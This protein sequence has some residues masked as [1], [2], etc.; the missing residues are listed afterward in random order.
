MDFPA[1][2]SEPVSTPRGLA[3]ALSVV[4]IEVFANAFNY[5][6]L[7]ESAQVLRE[8]A[9][10]MAA[11]A[12]M[13]RSGVIVTAPGDGIYDFV[14]RYFAPAKG[15]PEDPVTGAAHCMLA[16]YWAKRLGKPVLRAFQ[17]SRRGG[18]II[19]RPAGDRIEL[20]GS[21]VFYLEGEVEI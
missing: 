4:P 8:L 11:L 6:A 2:P 9:P 12:R 15:I 21:C 17:A 5:M 3:E 13:D 1:R 18:E 19:C 16:P 10:D 20:E 7:L 14:S